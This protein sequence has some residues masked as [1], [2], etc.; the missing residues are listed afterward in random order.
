MVYSKTLDI[1]LEE[2]KSQQKQ[3]LQTVAHLDTKAS[4]IIAVTGIILGV[5]FSVNFLNMD[6]LLILSFSNL[7]LFSGIILLFSSLIISAYSTKLTEYRFDPE[8]RPF[9]ENYSTEIPDTVKKRLISHFVNSFEENLEKIGE[10]GY[11]VNA[12]FYLLIIGLIF[13]MINIFIR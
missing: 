1:L 11:Y 5:I 12:S 7:M 10:K 6:S 3:T 9:V 2:S 4:I 13:L 8:L